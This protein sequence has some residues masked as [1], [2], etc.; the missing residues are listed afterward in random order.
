MIDERKIYMYSLI[1]IFIDA[2][3]LVVI[4]A[5]IFSYIKRG[6][7][8]SLVNIV[9]NLGSLLLALFLS[10]RLAPV[11]FDA[12]LKDMLVENTTEAITSG[13]AAAAD[14][15][16]S[17]FL[18]IFP[19]AFTN[20]LMQTYSTAISTNAG[21]SAELIVNDVMAPVVTPIVSL[22][23]FLIIFIVLKII[24]FLIEKSMRGI[25]RIP[26]VGGANR[27]LGAV[28][29]IVGG[30]INSVLVLCLFWALLAISGG[31]L[32]EFTQAD[33]AKS[34]AFGIFTEFN[35]FFS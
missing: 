33:M 23:L 25:N 26:L 12:F 21:Q 31:N 4:V 5:T 9:G 1:G 20:S 30:L 8:S 19:D 14:G 34:I 29:G 18:S 2:L 6:F 15:L 13:G 17:G 7:V 35:P 3:V 22:V 24:F 10:T 11:I 28:L 16:L 27:A 32:P